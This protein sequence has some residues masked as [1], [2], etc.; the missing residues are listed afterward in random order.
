MI[1]R[2]ALALLP[3]AALALSATPAA[4]KP[5]PA[6]STPAAPQADLRFK[7]LADQYIAGLARLSPVYGTTLG[8]HRYDSKLSD[9]SAAGRAARARETQRLLTMLELGLKEYEARYGELK[10]G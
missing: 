6:A 9:P 2:S 1:R 8:D 10:L 3:L 4:A 7:A 5:R